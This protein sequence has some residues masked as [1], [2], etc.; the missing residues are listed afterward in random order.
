M[1]ENKVMQYLAK[2]LVSDR[3]RVSPSPIPSYIERYWESTIWQT[4]I[5]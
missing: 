5:T 2:P 4:T 3:S 1:L